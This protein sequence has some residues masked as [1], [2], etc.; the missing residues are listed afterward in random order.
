M[1]IAGCWESIEVHIYENICEEMN[2]IK[3]LYG[4]EECEVIQR[5]KRQMMSLI[6]DKHIRRKKNA[7]H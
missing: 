5:V 2:S 3:D 1:Q 7:C 4:D 6:T